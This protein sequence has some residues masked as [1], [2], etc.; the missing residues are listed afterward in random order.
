M[1][2]FKWFLQNEAIKL[3]KMENLAQE[4]RCLK[5]NLMITRIRQKGPKEVSGKKERK[6]VK[7]TALRKY[8][9]RKRR[10]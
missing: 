3:A 10:K 5:Q 6:E 4:S 2:A 1:I 8:I 7:N 9:S